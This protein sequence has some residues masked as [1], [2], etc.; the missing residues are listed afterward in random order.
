ML[1]MGGEHIHE[2]LWSGLRRRSFLHRSPSR[3]VSTCCPAD[4]GLTARS[5]VPSSFLLQSES[6]PRGDRLRELSRAWVSMERCENTL[7]ERPRVHACQ[8]GRL[9][10]CQVLPNVYAKQGQTSSKRS[11]VRGAVK[12]VRGAQWNSPG[13]GAAAGR[14]AARWGVSPVAHAAALFSRRNRPGFGAGR[15]ALIFFLAA[16][17]VVILWSVLESRACAETV[18]LAGVGL[19]RGLGEQTAPSPEAGLRYCGRHLLLDGAW[20]GAAKLESGRGWGARGAG[21]VR[22]RG[23]GA[24]LAYTY[25]DGGAWTKSYPWA[26]VSAGA[27]PLRLIG[28]AT[29]GGYNRERKLEA[30]LT[31]RAGRLLIEPRVFVLRHLQGT[32]WGAALFLGLALDGVR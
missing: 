7:P 27:G 9:Q 14:S 10:R 11:V 19:T 3:L 29:L 1:A 5:Q 12:E 2:G 16:G 17:L 15:L 28:E 30:R 32:G 22:W 25:R 8:H 26:R 24:G 31:G 18:A 20:F 4:A 23:L 13:A 6:P 21:E